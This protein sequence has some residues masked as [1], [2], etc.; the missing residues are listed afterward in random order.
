MPLIKK[1]VETINR[2]YSKLSPES[3]LNQE[4]LDKVYGCL[5]SA[6]ENEENGKLR[7]LKD[8]KITLGGNPQKILKDLETLR[9]YCNK[10]YVE[11]GDP[12][13]QKRLTSGFLQQTEVDIGYFVNS[14][15][16]P[17]SYGE[18]IV[19]AINVSLDLVLTNLC[20]Y[21][22]SLRDI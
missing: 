16:Y 22:K 1:K 3:V 20:V 9:E 10:V 18:K 8:F 12:W 13:A 21:Q 17:E 11:A 15:Y 6:F 14:G 5:N 7:L 2:K 19:D 4:E